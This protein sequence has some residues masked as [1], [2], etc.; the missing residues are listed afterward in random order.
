MRSEVDKNLTNQLRSEVDKNLTNQLRSDVEKP[1]ISHTTKKIE[2]KKSN[3][4]KKTPA[5]PESLSNFLIYEKLYG[6]KSNNEKKKM[7]NLIFQKENPNIKEKSASLQ[8][9]N[10]EELSKMVL[11]NTL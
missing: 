3:L 9:I 10:V 5:I 6:K 8:N 2:E 11:T 4:N 1:V 7:M